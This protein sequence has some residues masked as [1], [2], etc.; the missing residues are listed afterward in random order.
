MSCQ[1]SKIWHAYYDFFGN[2]TAI[3]QSS[4][5][6]VKIFN[7]IYDVTTILPKN[8]NELSNIQNLTCILWFFCNPGSH[9]TFQLQSSYHTIF[10]LHWR[11]NIVHNLWCY[12]NL[13]FCRYTVINCYLGVIILWQVRERHIDKS[14][15]PQFPDVELILVAA[16]TLWCKT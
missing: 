9:L 13:I 12:H 1:T 14:D 2:L 6:V 10:V 16:D 4:C 3:S 7:L 5:K 8:D 15:F 11:K